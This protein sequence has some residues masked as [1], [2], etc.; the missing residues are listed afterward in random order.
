MS[1]FTESDMNDARRNPKTGDTWVKG[2]LVRTIYG[3]ELSGY[4]I[5]YLADRG[6]KVSKRSCWWTTW[7]DWTRTATLTQRGAK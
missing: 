4:K 1:Q 7:Q 3:F 2:V 6:A 5:L